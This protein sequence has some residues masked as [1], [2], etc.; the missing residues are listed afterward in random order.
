MPWKRI[1][2]YIT[3]SLNEER[4]FSVAPGHAIC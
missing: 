4:L 1:L 3:G 2:A